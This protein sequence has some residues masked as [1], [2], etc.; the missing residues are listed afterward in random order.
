[1][2][3]ET[4]APGRI[5][6]FGEHQDFLGL[7]VIASAIDL[8]IHITGRKTRGNELLIHMPDIGEDEI[9]N[10]KDEIKY[11]K[12]RD[13][14]KAGV[15]VLLDRGFKINFGA[16]CT[17][18]GELPINA[19]VSSSSALVVGWIKFLLTLLDIEIPPDELARLA[20]RAEVLEF[21]E[22]GG[23]M[24]HFTSSIGNTIFVDCIPPFSYQLLPLN[25][26]GFVLGDTLERKETLEVLKRSHEEAE[27]GIKRL[28][29]IYP[30]FD[31]RKTPLHEVEPYLTQ[32]PS[33]LADKVY[34][35]IVNR[36]ICLTAKEMFE[37]RAIDERKIGNLLN[38]HHK[39]L[40]ILGVSTPKLD[41]LCEASLKAGAFGAKLVGSGGGGCMI[42]Y[43]PGRE[44][45]VA[46]A[47]D[48]AGGKAFIVKIEEGCR[49]RILEG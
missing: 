30:L 12:K 5:C 36:D 22:P 6:L 33:H 39:M 14:L 2:L 46:K 17:V 10:L 31:L 42:A 7:W 47:I 20:H 40:R 3:V 29:E 24:D 37:Q 25:L 16:E 38:E 1:M 27:E 4:I 44:K 35:N 11:T 19:G 9:I 43:A 18:R 48:E 28:K 49:S 41:S 21:N 13:Y 45:E 15:K 8:H 26:Q 23:M 34:V 32:L